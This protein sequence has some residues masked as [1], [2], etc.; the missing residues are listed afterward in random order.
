MYPIEHIEHLDP[1]IIGQLMLVWESAVRASHAFLSEQDI[2]GLRPVV[3]EALGIVDI[4]AIRQGGLIRG[5]CGL[6]DDKLEM[7]FVHAQAQR[8]G[9]GRT[10]FRQAIRRGVVRLDVNEQNPKAVEFYRRMG[11]E[12]VGRSAV[13]GQGNPFPLL[14]MR[15][16]APLHRMEKPEPAHK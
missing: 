14:H 10:L 16:A 11:F 5:F 15:L 13:D 4:W 2:V 3:F 1:A 12:E 9:M 8:K 6:H 7:L